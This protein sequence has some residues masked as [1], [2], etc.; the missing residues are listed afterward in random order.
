MKRI[1]FSALFFTA[2]VTVWHLVVL[3]KIW[4]VVLLPDPI[5]VWEYL[6]GAAGDGTLLEASIVTMRRLLAGYIIGIAAG[7]PLRL[8]TARFKVKNA[9]RS[10]TVK[11]KELALCLEIAELENHVDRRR[12]SM[13]GINGVVFG[14]AQIEIDAPLLVGETRQAVQLIDLAG[15]KNR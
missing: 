3:A 11:V 9:Q 5:S 12:I 14:W 6:D 7:L 13:H 2:L 10:K 4:S 15:G 1:I 8:L